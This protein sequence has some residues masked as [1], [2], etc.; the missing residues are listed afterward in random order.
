MRRALALALALLAAFS[1]PAGSQATASR[2]A[3]Q[4]QAA[5]NVFVI[6]LGRGAQYWEK[7]GHNMLWFF[8]PA[9]GLDL[10]YNWGSFDFAQPGFLRRQ[11]LGDPLYWVDTVP[12]QAVVNYYRSRDRTITVQQLNFTPHEARR[13]LELAR[14]NMRPENRNYRYD[15]F[16]DNCSTRIRDLIDRAL[17]GALEASTQDTVD[18]SYRL[19]TLRLLDDMKLTQLGVD[20]ALGRPADRRLTRWEGMFI[21]MRLRDVLHD[22]RISDTAGA[23][24]PLVS[25]EQVVYETQR[26]HERPAPPRLWLPYLVVGGIIALILLQSGVIGARSR[27]VEKVFRFEGALWAIATGILGAILLVAWLG[28]KHVFWYRNENLFLVNPLSLSLAVL[29]PLSFWRPRFLKPAAIVAI[30]VAMLGAL[31]LLLKGLP[32]FQQHNIELVAL[33]LPAHF[34]IAYQFWRRAT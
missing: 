13:A 5:P 33:T 19:E 6:T 24:R 30:L 4:P 15:Y 11:L 2:R 17:G 27:L 16:L 23:A 34:A 28:T 31:G 29:A 3:V 7:Y 10:A 12:G 18:R 22:L 8:D 9:S 32:W 14:D 26:F 1:L 20:F 21:P 25:R